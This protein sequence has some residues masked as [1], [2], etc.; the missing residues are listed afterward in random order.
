MIIHDYPWFTAGWGVSKNMWRYWS[1]LRGLRGCPEIIN[2]LFGF[3]ILNQLSNYKYGPNMG[4]ITR[5]CMGFSEAMG[6]P[7]VT[8]VVS[9]LRWSNELDDYWG[10]H[11]YPNFRKPPNVTQ[12]YCMSDSLVWPDNGNRIFV[13]FGMDVNVGGKWSGSM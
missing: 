13:S 9:I 7:Q 10:T 12:G 4:H 11:G 5:H 2:V 1:L 3:S 8:M 6:D